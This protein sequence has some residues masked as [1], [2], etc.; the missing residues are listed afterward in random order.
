MKYFISQYFKPCIQPKLADHIKKF[1]NTSID[2]SDGLLADLQ[3]LINT[4]KL[5][6]KLYLNKIPISTN[7]RKVLSQKRLSKINYI[8]NGDDYQVLFTASKN[9][10]RIIKKIASKYRIK[11]T[12]I[13]SIQNLTKKSLLVDHNDIKLSLKNKGYFHKF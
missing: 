4:Q 9:K 7:L 5:T 6:Y 2:I 8:S 13:G 10:K 1:A 12:K 3:K 11:L